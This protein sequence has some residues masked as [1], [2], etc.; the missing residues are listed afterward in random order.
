[1]HGDFDA[2][3]MSEQGMLCSFMTL[4]EITGE[5]LNLIIL[6]GLLLFVHARSTRKKNRVPWGYAC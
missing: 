5:I 3:E 4:K 2:A 1:M 6:A